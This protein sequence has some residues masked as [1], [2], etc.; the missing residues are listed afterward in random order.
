MDSRFEIRFTDYFKEQWDSYGEET[1]EF[2]EN[3]VRLLAWNPFRFE[4]HKGYKNVFKIKLTVR[5]RYSRLMY[6]VFYPDERSITIL[7]VFPRH[8]DYKDFERLFGY[9]K[10]R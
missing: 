2:I 3:K 4:T 8:S 9:L 6:A 10:K 1:R 7:G 5:D